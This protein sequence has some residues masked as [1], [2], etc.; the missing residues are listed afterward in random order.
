M[1]LFVYQVSNLKLKLISKLSDENFYNKN[2]N[3]FKLLKDPL[4]MFKILPSLWFF[5]D[6]II[7]FS[8][9]TLNLI[10]KSFRLF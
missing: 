6:N 4:Q 2:D 8:N 9:H 3:K 1:S 10:Y 7:F 5:S